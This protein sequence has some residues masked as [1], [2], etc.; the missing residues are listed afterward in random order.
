MA[1]YFFLISDSNKS[2]A[3]VLT[4]FEDGGRLSSYSVDG[5][6]FHQIRYWR[7]IDGEFGYPILNRVFYINAMD[8]LFTVWPSNTFTYFFLI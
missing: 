8:L 1:L 3:D 4:E 6:R 2:M 5:V 7:W